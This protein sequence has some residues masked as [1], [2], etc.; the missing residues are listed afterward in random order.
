MWVN[1]LISATNGRL[2]QLITLIMFPS[3][4]SPLLHQFPL[5][6][7]GTKGYLFSQIESSRIVTFVILRIELLGG[8]PDGIPISMNEQR[9]CVSWLYHAKIV[10]RLRGIE[11][12]LHED[13]LFTT[14]KAAQR[15]QCRSGLNVVQPD[16]LKL[17][18]TRT[19]PMIWRWTSINRLTRGHT[20]VSTFGWPWEWNW[21]A[22]P[23]RLYHV[24]ISIRLMSARAFLLY[25][26]F[27]LFNHTQGTLAE[28]LF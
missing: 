13:I 15:A 8:R 26:L 23:Q 21:S 7:I 20:K 1:V 25:D 18:P 19:H 11:S 6:G 17:D 9:S 3:P 12:L 2:S 28:S 5:N 14:V 24:A 27:S 10:S 22:V 4:S 16:I